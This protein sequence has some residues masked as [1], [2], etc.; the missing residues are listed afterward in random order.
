MV[1]EEF[2]KKFEEMIEKEL[3]EGVKVI[4]KFFYEKGVEDGR[5]SK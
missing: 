2:V 4:L 3:D 1:F 5:S